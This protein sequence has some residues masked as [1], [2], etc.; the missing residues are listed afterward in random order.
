MKLT[1]GKEAAYIIAGEGCPFCGKQAQVEGESVETG[2]GEASQGMYCLGCGAH[3][4]DLYTLTRIV[5]VD[6]P[7]GS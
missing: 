2:A 5:V 6:E 4:T 7:E 3:W 1:P